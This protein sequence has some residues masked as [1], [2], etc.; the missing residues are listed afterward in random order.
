[1]AL[2]R[3]IYAVPRTNY[4]IFLKVKFNFHDYL[5]AMLTTCVPRARFAVPWSTRLDCPA[6]K[7]MR[8]ELLGGW[9]KSIEY[10]GRTVFFKAG[11]LMFEKVVHMYNL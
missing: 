8:V 2:W 3:K 9:L 1:M 7:Y 10:Q 4:F 11:F 5:Q 6:G